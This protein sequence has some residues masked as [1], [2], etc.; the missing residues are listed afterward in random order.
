MIRPLRVA[1]RRI[2]PVLAI[3]LPGLVIAALAVRR[4]VPVVGAIPTDAHRGQLLR[5]VEGRRG[6]GEPLRIS[7]YRVAAGELAVSVSASALRGVPELLA[8]WVP[9]DGVD[10]IANGTLLG[11]VRSDTPIPLPARAAST[12]G[13]LALYDL[14]HGEVA[15][16]VLLPAMAGAS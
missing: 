7:I 1:H 9:T 14:A 13:V 5:E 10:P 8:Y 3:V 16:T 11:Q 4:P 6:D 2:W 15:A 12:P